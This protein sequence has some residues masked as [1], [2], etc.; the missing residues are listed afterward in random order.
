M[1]RNRY[2]DTI[3]AVGIFLVILGHH[4]TIFTQYIFSFHM[5]LFFFLSG[6]FHKN[7]GSYKIFFEKKVKSLIIPYFFFAITLFLFWLIIGR[8]FGESKIKNISVLDSLKGI[9]LGM[10]M[11]GVSSMDWGII[12]WFLLTLFIITNMYYFISKL[13]N[14]LLII[15]INIFLGVIGFYY[16][17]YKPSYFDIWHFTVALNAIQFYSMGV[18][19]KNRILDLSKISYKWIF[20]LFIVS[21]VSNYYNGKIDMQSLSYGRN[22]VLFY[23]SAFSGIGFIIFLIR[24]LEIYNRFL[25]FIGTNTMIILAYHNRCMTFIKFIF[26]IIGIKIINDNT[27][28]NVIFSIVQLILCIPIIIVLNKYFPNFVG[29]YSRK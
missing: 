13:N 15:F 25:D 16:N 21:Y 14:I 18:I 23:I 1:K 27:I 2:I 11:L 4:Q 20:L 5:P 24:N 12:L 3:K 7:Y 10:D 22:I 19:L 9:F 28:Y 6:I 29:K 8:H 26:V 17:Y